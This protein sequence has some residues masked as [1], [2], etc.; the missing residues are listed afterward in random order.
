MLRQIIQ[1]PDPRLAQKSAPIEQVGEDIRILATDMLDTLKSIGG[2][3]LAA[4][5]IGVHKRLVIID[6]AQSKEDPDAPQNFL[7]I[8]NPRITVLDKTPH[9]ENEG[10]LSVSEFRAEVSRPRLVA[11]DGTDLDGNPVRLEGE[12]YYGACLQHEIDH[13]DGVLFIDRISYL[14]RS[15]YDKKLGKGKIK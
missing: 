13:L 6:I 8:L 12:G 3:G 10:C 14:K 5:Q 11:L 15:L 7:P 1:Y 9:R 4:S 2:L